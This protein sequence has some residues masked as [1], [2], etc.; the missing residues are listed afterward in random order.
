M[1]KDHKPRCY[2]AEPRTLVPGIKLEVGT[3]SE[4]RQAEVFIVVEGGTERYVAKSG[5][6]YP[7]ATLI[8]PHEYF[9]TEKHADAAAWVK[10]KLAFCQY[11]A[12]AWNQA[13]PEDD[14]PPF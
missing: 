6:V 13:S 12:C 1:E 5:T 2:R 4:R 9:L 11:P 7:S 14:M 10:H 3:P 8:P